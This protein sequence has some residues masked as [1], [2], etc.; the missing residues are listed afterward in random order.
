MSTRSRVLSFISSFKDRD[1]PKNTTPAAAPAAAPPRVAEE[2]FSTPRTP[3]IR[4][5]TTNTPQT[6]YSQYQS[7]YDGSSTQPGQ[8]QRAMSNRPLSM[9]QT[10]HPSLMD[11]TQDTLPELQ[12]IFTFLNSHAN[13]LYQEGYFLKLDDQ[14]TQ[15]KPNADRS[16]T[17]CFAQ[18]V[19]TVLSLWDASEL[20]EAGQEGEVLPKFINLTDASIKMIEALPTR[21]D[22]EAPLQN[23]LSIST[24]GKNRY[25]LH[26]NSHHSLIQ[27]VAGIRLSMFEHATLQEAYTG[28]LIAG[29]GKALNNINMI[30]DRARMPTAD[31]ARV[32]FGAG[33]P[34]RRCWCVIS[35]PDEK[36]V[37][38]IQKQL[39]KKKSAYDHSRPP[40]LKGDIKF[41][42]T[43]KT[44]KVHP[45][46]TI[47]DAY[48][49]FAIYPQSKPLIDAS[50]L[51][52][53]EGTIT[54]HSSPPS[55]SEGFVFVMP[56]VHPA[57]TGFEMMLRWLFPVFDTF[58]LYGRPGRLIADTTDSRSLMFAMPKHRRYGYLEILDVSGLIL[59]SGSGSWKEGEWRKRMKALT[60]KRMTV[61]EN[62]TQ[63]NIR[64]SSRRSTRNSFGPSH[65]RIRFDDGAS[66]RSSPPKTS[67]PGQTDGAL[68]GV[69]RTDSAPPGTGAFALPPTAQTSAHAR[70][71]SE[72]QGFPGYEE[73][74]AASYDGAYDMAPTPPP[75]AAGVTS[76]HGL[77]PG[78]L[79]ET[80]TTPDRV[81]SEDEYVARSTPVR[82]LQ[83]LQG[84][85]TPEPVA[86]PPA[87][88]HAPG[89][90]P[91]AKPYQSP[92]I[93]REN[94]RMSSATLSQLAGA[95]GVAGVV[96]YNAHGDAVGTGHNQRHQNV[97]PE[98]NGNRGVQPVANLKE[99]PANSDGLE[100]VVTA[101][102]PRFSFEGP[103]HVPRTD[104][105]T[106][107]N[108]SHPS[109]PLPDTSHHPLPNPP[110]DSS[111]GPQS[112]PRD[113]LFTIR[114]YEPDQIP[115]SSN[116]PVAPIGHGHYP[117]QSVDSTSR[118]ASQP[119]RLQTR[120]SIVR[121]PLPRNSS[122]R[123]PV[124][125]E[126]Q[127]SGGS[128]GQYAIDQAAFDM[129]GR[130]N[131]R[132]MPPPEQKIS[133]QDTDA[134]SEYDDC[135]STVSPD[136]ASTHRSDEPRQSIERPRAGVLKTVGNASETDGSSVTSPPIDIDFGPTYNLTSHRA[137]SPGPTLA[138]DSRAASP[139]P[140]QAF[141]AR[142]ASPAF[143]YPSFQ[144]SPV[145]KPVSYDQPKTPG[146]KAVTP[147]NAHYRNNSSESRTVAWQPGM[148]A[149]GNAGK[150]M[151]IT[152]EQFV[153]KRA[154][155]QPASPLYSHQRQAS[156]NTLRANSSTPSLLNRNSDFYSHS[157]NNSTDIIQ[158]PG[159]WGAGVALGRSGT[160]DM[161]TAL[162]A[163]EQEKVAKMTGTPLISM[164]QN[165]KAHA[166]PSGLVGAIEAREREKQQIKQ[167]INSAAV[168]NA[169]TQRQQ[170]A[171]YE[172]QLH[173]DQLAAQY[174]GGS[175]QYGVGQHP[176]Q[177][178]VQMQQ[179]QSWV[180]P[181]ASVFAQ[182]G[183]WVPSAPSPGYA[184]IEQGR[185][186]PSQ[187][188]NQHQ[189]Y[190]PQQGAHGRG[191][192][193]GGYRGHG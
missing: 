153:Q 65:S 150:R 182:G 170:Q 4:S 147:E 3:R 137:P 9:I 157:R 26:F 116:T 31:W 138:Y 27:W 187:Y 76:A 55:T 139:G 94:S 34:W 130:G 128:L 161:T 64:H 114:T 72:I 192:G 77:T 155:M 22:S 95:A 66:I 120:A 38:K 49:A 63:A 181:T 126:T 46:A 159:S 67:G 169:I 33:T 191:N 134:S 29:K 185:Q 174:R 32:R 112:L 142:A 42:D 16:W 88:S 175:Q 158:R 146:R 136:Y 98:E 53:V 106:Q 84:S 127:S 11:V 70:S 10:Y 20:D 12:P 135:A 164:A 71:A 190:T 100:G 103:S 47:T 183:G 119:S 6:P 113:Q 62:S 97:G 79:A 176:Q 165:S 115:S 132:G 186:S 59:E 90:L 193:S 131:H 177:H 152:A 110:A 75:H 2:P 91:I 188:P 17:E 167:G 101:S 58:G 92:D 15:G 74:V 107:P 154:S 25:L 37:Q 105:D 129:I 140:A 166:T 56:E 179:Q 52:K 68:G 8:R 180:S 80:G 168:Q 28:A 117:Q 93:L 7:Q 123:T 61:V 44:K 35:P 87:F 69:P 160:G 73:P 81:S 148:S 40:I 36:E 50:T 23:V 163:R 184:G 111:A 178:P 83:E 172:Q 125:A 99:N 82:E 108:H 144:G 30:M 78:Y 145:R 124:S 19:G 149:S 48:S 39:L 171:L 118:I 104:F 102:K 141:G 89:S 133:R 21:S 14:N 189:Y 54:I 24:A 1:A 57:V 121:K 85:N 122:I 51:V 5:N 151:S 43:K 96:G 86:T 173:Q 18:L 41:Y 109:L 60:S 45:I 156:S 162:S 143:N 13:K